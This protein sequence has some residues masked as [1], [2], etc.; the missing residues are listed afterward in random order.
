MTTL[1]K[2]FLTFFISIATVSLAQD[3][4]GVATYKSHR[5]VDLK[6][7][8]KKI[9]D[10][11]QKQIEAQIREQFQQ[12]YTLKFTKDESFY[13]REEK[14]SKPN[15]MANKGGISITMSQSTDHL[16]KNLKDQ[17]FTTETEIQGKRFLI[18][19]S[20]QNRG[21]ELSGETKNIGEYTCYKAV[22]KDSI[23]TT[24]FTDEGKIE[25]IKKEKVTTAWYT[26][27]IPISNGPADFGGLP[28]LILEINDGDLTLICSRIVINPEER[29]EIN[30]PKKGKVVTQAKFDEIQDKKQ[31][32][33][34][35]QLQTRR[36]GKDGSFKVISVSS[37]G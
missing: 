34:M 25:K 5:K 28:G 27:Q 7:G 19:D 18:K 21:W 15:P 36:R 14:L 35:E 1:S 10:D 2:L 24:T 33:M 12:T 22:L 11:L 16:Y 9:N 20:I 29:F 4:Q 8:N 17:R 3:F 37:G 30:E 26:P 13:K 32:E 6:M 23:T 31:K